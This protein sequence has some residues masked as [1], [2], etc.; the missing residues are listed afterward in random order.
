MEHSLIYLHQI[1]AIAITTIITIRFLLHFVCNFEI[2]FVIN[3]IDFGIYRSANKITKF[4]VSMKD[5]IWMFR[6]IELHLSVYWLIAGCLSKSGPNQ[7]SIQYAIDR[8]IDDHV[9]FWEIV[10]FIT[11]FRFNGHTNWRTQKV[12]VLFLLLSFL[13]V[14]S[15]NFT[16]IAIGFSCK[17]PDHIPGTPV[18]SKSNSFASFK[19]YVYKRK[20][21]AHFGDICTPCCWSKSF[22][23][24][25]IERKGKYRNG[26][27]SRTLKC[28]LCISIRLSESEYGKNSL[29][30][31]KQ[32][33][34]N[35]NNK[36]F[37]QI[38]GR[39]SGFRTNS[40]DWPQAIDKNCHT[41]IEEKRRNTWTNGQPNEITKLLT[42]HHHSIHL[43]HIYHSIEINTKFS[44][45]TIPIE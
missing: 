16:E 26:I 25:L 3:A 31:V 8:M 19:L 44:C 35:D 5:D 23:L 10:K 7:C 42:M 24:M 13:F 11:S 28:S 2:E 43:A 27:S 21:N 41:K 4:P 15:F 1:K 29:E 36:P 39:P 38:A 20:P 9:D 45:F 33:G 22:Q 37:Q 40:G 32:P 14:S 12:L 17:L 18:P 34:F 30:V 6:S